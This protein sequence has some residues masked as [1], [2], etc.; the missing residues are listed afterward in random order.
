MDNLALQQAGYHNIKSILKFPNNEIKT[1]EVLRFLP[2]KRVVFK[3]LWHDKEVVIK[4]FFHKDR[5]K[6]N[7]QFQKE[8]DTIKFLTNL[9]LPV[10]ELLDYKKVYY[11]DYSYVVTKFIEPSSKKLIDIS[12]FFKAIVALHNYGIYQEDIHLN[13]FINHDGI[14]HY[15]DAMEINLKYHHQKLP[16]KIALDNLALFISQFSV[17]EQSMHLAKLNEY[18]D[19]INFLDNAEVKSNLSKYKKYIYNKSQKFFSKRIHD[20]SQKVFRDC[21]DFIS[22]EKVY[23]S[24]EKI[25]GVF[26]R[27]EYYKDQEFLSAFIANQEKVKNNTLKYFKKGNTAE[28]FLLES[29]NQKYVV[30][31]YKVKNLF[32]SIRNSIQ[33]TRAKKSWLQA[34][35]CNFLGI[36]TAK[37]IGFFEIKKFGIFRGAYFITKYNENF[38]NL[39]GLLESNAKLKNKVIADEI[40]SNLHS[41]KINKIYHGDFKANNML[42]SPDKKGQGIILIDL[43]QMQKVENAKYFN[44]LHNKDRA[45]LLRSLEHYKDLHNLVTQKLKV[46]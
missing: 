11:R 36:N 16:I 32:H 29:D 20:Y 23:A 26:N 27:N 9:K 17:E 24:K 45:R 30:K 18:F 43:E 1:L 12:E 44:Y 34:N 40:V 37:P 28:V 7:A 25:T 22:C 5:K 4:L 46:K 14:I 21:S 10:P 38:D 3:A 35:L 41:L 39:N 2:H 19:N 42:T 13:N 6:R 15:L 33:K 8:V 31:Y